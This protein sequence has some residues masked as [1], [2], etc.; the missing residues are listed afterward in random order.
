MRSHSYLNSAKK[1]IESYDGA[2]PLAAWLKDHFRVNKKF[3]S[4][5][6]REVSHTCYCFFR[7]GDA[8]AELEV[9]ERMLIALFLCSETSSLVLQELKPAWNE[10]VQV[11]LQQKLEMINGCSELKNL[12]PFA[13]YLSSEIDLNEFLASHLVQPSLFLRIRPGASA[14]VLKAFDDAGISYLNES[15]CLR[16]PN[17]TKVENVV[18]IDKDVVIQDL[19]SQKTLDQLKASNLKPQAEA[20]D[21]CAASGGKSI[22]LYDLFPGVRLTVSDVRESILVNL[23]KRFFVADIKKYDGFVTDLSSPG[24]SL[25]K[26]FD[27][28]ICDAPCS[29]SGTWG[30]TPEQLK[31]FK[32]EKISHYAS[33]QKKIAANA[34]KCLKKGGVFVYI[35]CSVFSAENEEVVEFILSNTG[36]QLQSQQYL[37]GYDKK[38]DTLF[39]ALFSL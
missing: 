31:F 37:K 14:K 17:G 2:I 20:W 36:M 34:S 3:G 18:S 38:A 19:N 26:S 6:R 35:T 39:V 13:S 1:I 9:E 4:K 25:S 8:F 7:L 22:L 29:G 15:N 11:S 33:L 32:I 10:L 5:D 12:F 30:R 16:L 24:F 27:L 28:I 21:C 23:R